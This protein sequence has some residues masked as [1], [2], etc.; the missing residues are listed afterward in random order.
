ME[1]AD[2]TL[3]ECNRQQSIQAKSKNKNTSLAQTYIIYCCQSVIP[4][5]LFMFFG[6]YFNIL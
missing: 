6:N 3:L 4:S 1:F 2:I 5:L